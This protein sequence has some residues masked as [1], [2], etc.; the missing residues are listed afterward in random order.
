M[1]STHK[2]NK[3]GPKFYYV[4][5]RFADPHPSDIVIPGDAKLKTPPKMPP[6]PEGQTAWHAKTKRWWRTWCETPQATIFA[7]SDWARLESLMPLAELWFT[8]S[9]DPRVFAEL[10]RGE[11]AF[12]ATLLDRKRLGIAIGDKAS[13]ADKIAPIEVA[14]PRTKAPKVTKGRKA[15]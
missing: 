3:R 1:A 14:D 11:E 4:T 5:E 6:P 9:A 15:S 2:G 12:G 8:R 13:E 10:R 7:K